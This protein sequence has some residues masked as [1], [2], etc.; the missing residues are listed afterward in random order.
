MATVIQPADQ[1]VLMDG[2]SWETYEALLADGG[3]CRQ[4]RMAFDQGV[5]EIVTPSY[6]HERF[7]DVVSGVAEE[8]LNA[9]GQDYLRSG[10][11]TFKQEGLGRGFEPDASF[12]VAHAPR[13]RGLSRIDLSNDPPPDL[14]IEV[15]VARSSL[16]KLPIYAALAVPEVWRYRADRVYVHRLVN[17]SYVEVDQSKVLPGL[18][19]MQLTT[20]AQ[21]G[22]WETRQAWRQ[23]IHN[24]AHEMRA[25]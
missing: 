16:D 3:D 14:I 10:S 21:E 20:F 24:W 1:P 8:I 19:S 15:D 25:D 18:T 17:S 12:Y 4:T 7:R 9:R 13:I 5:L 23:R 6:E 2:V 11:T 22:L